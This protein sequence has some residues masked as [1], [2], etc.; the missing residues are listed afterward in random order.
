MKE[1]DKRRR[2]SSLGFDKGVKSCNFSF[3]SS[4]VSRE[5]DTYRISQPPATLGTKWK[6]EPAS[7]NV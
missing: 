7:F 4:I 3:P 6:E 2:E 1:V 5:F